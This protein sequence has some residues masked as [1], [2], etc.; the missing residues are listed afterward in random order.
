MCAEDKR[1][2][3]GKKKKKHNARKQK[4]K[5]S[6]LSHNHRVGRRPQHHG[7]RHFGRFG[8][9]CQGGDEGE[10]KFKRGARAARRDD[11]A[12]DDD[13]VVGVGRVGQVFDKGGVG[14]G[15]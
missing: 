11:V 10:R 13:A 8:G 15:C 12:V 6:P 7:P 4:K 9:A 3:G 5:L 14:G 1:A 2:A